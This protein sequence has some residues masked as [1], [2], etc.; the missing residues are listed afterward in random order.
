MTKV[1]NLVDGGSCFNDGHVYSGR[2]PLKRIPG[3]REGIED[4]LKNGIVRGMF[5]P[6]R[7]WGS[8]APEHPNQ[9]Q[10]YTPSR[11]GSIDEVAKMTFHLS[12][13]DL[14]ELMYT[15]SYMIVCNDGDGKGEK[16]SAAE[17][18]RVII[19]SKTCSVEEQIARSVYADTQLQAT[20]SRALSHHV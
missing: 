2:A 8:G 20:P 13:A 17:S 11:Y 14:A 1:A 16:A 3:V 10:C 5:L 18:L 19:Y 6:R 15:I 9:P 7:S 4:E 12:Y